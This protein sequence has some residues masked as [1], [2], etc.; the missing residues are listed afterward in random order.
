MEPKNPDYVPFAGKKI[1][2]VF[3]G[4]GG[5]GAYEI[6]VW[7]GLCEKGIS[8]FAAISGTSIGGLNGYL[9]ARGDLE[10][11]E[12][13]WR[14]LGLNSPLKLSWVR[15]V[16]G[17]FERIG[18]AICLAMTTYVYLPVVGLI[19]V[20]CTFLLLFPILQ[21]DFLKPAQVIFPMLGVTLVLLA[22]FLLRKT[23]IGRMGFSR[24][25]PYSTRDHRRLL[26]FSFQPW[27]N[28]LFALA[29]MAVLPMWM[30]QRDVGFRSL[31]GGW[32][33]VFPILVLIGLVSIYLSIEL[34][35][36]SISQI[37]IF[38]GDSLQRELNP[39]LEKDAHT[40]ESGVLRL[41][42]KP[43]LFATSL[44][45]RPIALPGLPPTLA[46][47]MEYFPLRDAE[48][49]AARKVLSATGAIAGFLPRVYEDRKMVSFTVA[50]MPQIY[51]DAGMID[52]TPIAPLLEWGQC[53]VIIAVLLDHRIKNG[54]DYIGRYL[55]SVNRRVRKVN[56][57]ISDELWWGA[58]NGFRP[59]FPARASSD[60]FV[61]IQLVPIVPSRSIGGGWAT[62][63]FNSSRIERLLKLGYCDAK[64][65]IDKALKN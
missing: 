22:K 44:V 7:R 61:D 14:G 54:P 65:A 27:M 12:R 64:A 34:G 32:F 58:L 45:E 31:F 38:S 57:E 28:W 51:Y 63:R 25:A 26:L 52:N 50:E 6:G 36:S 15:L 3:T 39:L 29:G 16:L 8:N 10:G 40:D 30:L 60:Q 13:L 48:I 11:A 56:P 2:L 53:D 47:G 17:L 41:R 20:G 42:I 4:G 5:K 23:R 1:G 35:F 9:V 18:I 59:L 24:D 37:P 33:W 62:F 19:G 49:G 55:D 43:H 46:L 21:F